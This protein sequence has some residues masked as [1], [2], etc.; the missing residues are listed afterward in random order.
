MRF[1][2]TAL[3]GSLVVA[4]GLAAAPGPASAQ[5]WRGASAL[6]NAEVG[7]AQVQQVQ[8]RRWRHRHYRHRD[9]G[10]GPALGGFAAGAI[11]GGAIASQ[12]AQSRHDWLAYCSAKYRSFD[13]ASGT[14]LGYDGRLHPCR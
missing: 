9:R 2:L 4:A 1:K 5:S 13:P 7:Q 8:Y 14:Y 3:A 11:I 6:A 10:W 12:Q